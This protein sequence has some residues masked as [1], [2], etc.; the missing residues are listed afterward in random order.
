MP[1]ITERLL[2][3]VAK[4]WI[5][6][7]GL[8]DA[9]EA[10]KKTNERR[11]RVIINRLGEHTPDLKLI[12]DYTLEYLRIV[13]LLDSN[14]IDGTIS[15][16]PSQLGLAAE[17]PLYKKNL[18]RILERAEEAK[19]DVWIDMENSPYTESTIQVYREQFEDHPR[20]GIC[21]QAN[22]RRSEND[23]KGLLAIG[24]RVR[25]VKGAYPESAKIAY[26]R[27]EVEENYLRLLKMMFEGGD[28]FVVGTH[29]SKLINEALR[30][31]KENKRNFEFEMLKGIRDDLK[32]TLVSQGQ[33]VGEYIPYGPEW[34]NYSKR[35]M[36]ERTRNILLLLRS[37]TG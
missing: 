29:D 20:M 13:D 32:D 30:L 23:L 6:G 11:I 21:L 5:A 3:R 36:R 22:L 8:D 18:T 17:V 28:E 33:R 12:E 26:K 16:K 1:G 19:R 15:I 27:S 34:Y 37:I 4:R 14:I 7:Y 9:I 35:R 10:A 25:L 2:Y 24:G 31:D